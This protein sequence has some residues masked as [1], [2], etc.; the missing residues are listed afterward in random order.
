MQ[1]KRL[2]LSGFK[3]FVDAT[4]L[5]IEPGLTGIVGPNGC[6]KSNVVE[7]IR[8]V[9]GEQRAATFRSHRMEEVIFSGTRQ[10]KPLGMSEVSLTIENKD[11]TLPIEFGEVTLTPP[12]LPLGRERLPAQSRDAD[13]FP[14]LGEGA[15]QGAR[16]GRSVE[17]DCRLV[18]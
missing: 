9:L 5:R 12:P 14:G 16:A 6:G 7:A 4:E 18:A 3:S 11:H 8:W 1:I 15:P 2:K 17:D 13:V 10:R